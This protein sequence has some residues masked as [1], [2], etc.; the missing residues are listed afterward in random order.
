MINKIYTA[1]EPPDTEAR[2]PQPIPGES[3]LLH[4]QLVL[5]LRCSAC[6]ATTW[7]PSLPADEGTRMVAAGAVVVRVSD[8]YERWWHRTGCIDR[9][10][11]DD[12][13]VPVSDRTFAAMRACWS[14]EPQP[15]GEVRLTCP[16]CA[17]ALKQQGIGHRTDLR[18]RI[19]ARIGT[20]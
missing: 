9:R 10:G 3:T 1:P 8:R 18:Y 16:R 17:A 13:A 19:L 11:A 15:D 4:G 14:T 20:P 7:T 6:R 5:P 2:S 12:E